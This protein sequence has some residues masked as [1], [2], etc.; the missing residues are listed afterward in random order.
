[1]LWPL[2]DYLNLYILRKQPIIVHQ[3][4]KVGSMSIFTSLKK[5]GCW[6]FHT[7][8]LSFEQITAALKNGDSN[9]PWG[10]WL[11]LHNHFVKKRKPAKYITLFRDPV[12]RA[13][14]R[15][16]ENLDEHAG[17]KD[18]HHHLSLAEIT[19]VFLQRPDFFYE[20]F[21]W[22]DRQIKAV[23]G[24]DVFQITFPKE[25]GTIHI[26]KDN[27]DLL[28]IKSEADDRVKERCLAEF[29]QLDHFKLE[30][31]NTSGDKAFGKIYKEFL[32]TIALPPKL[33][34]D[35]YNAQVV[36]HFYTEEEIEQMRSR[37][38]R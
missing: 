16:F 6:V 35:C 29:L 5:Q 22:F 26:T 28:V 24:I 12:A 32:Q 1:M 8:S 25:K 7:H 18:A 13:I 11:W 9:N 38:L 31:A 4:G 34:D 21:T 37:W 30:R 33:I 2:R 10:K 14:S 15:Y 23:L 20:Q 19:E 36:R 27:V 3:M 17:K